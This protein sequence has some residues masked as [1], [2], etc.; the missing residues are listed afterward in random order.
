MMNMN[1]FDAEYPTEQ[2]LRQIDIH[3]LLPQQEPFVMIGM[4]THFDRTLTVT[5][6]EVKADN[7]FVEGGL[8]SASKDAEKG[9][10]SASGL[11]ENIAQTCAA[12]IGYVNKYILKKG[13]QLG[14]IGAV[15]N[16]EIMALPQVGDIITTR[17]EVKEEVF[18][19]TL[20]EATVTCKG[21]TLVSTEMKIAVKNSEE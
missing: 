19:M 10:L 7:I 9:Y 13:I 1:N 11:M 15:R 20:A 18:G 8:P 21:K 6:T 5:E 12:R 3:E 14:F 4:L 17:V 16:F 2:V